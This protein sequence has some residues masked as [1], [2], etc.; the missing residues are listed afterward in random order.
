M[1]THIAAIIHAIQLFGTCKCSVTPTA[2]NISP[3]MN[4]FSRKYEL[5]TKSP[6]NKVIVLITLV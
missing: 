1:K 5:G 2:S 3:R 6:C 4:N